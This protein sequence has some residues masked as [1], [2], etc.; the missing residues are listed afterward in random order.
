[1]FREMTGELLDG[2]APGVIASRFHN[3]VARAS[4]A[5]AREIHK[6]TGLT[7]VVLSGGTFQN[8]YLSE[9]LAGMLE[10]EA[11]EV[12]RHTR[13]PANDGGLALGQLAIASRMIHQPR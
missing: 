7:K 10:E 5:V 11:F 13:V 4:L 2:V 9:R 8:R 6:Q 1:M 3:T 12:F